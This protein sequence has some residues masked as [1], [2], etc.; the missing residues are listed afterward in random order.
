MSILD[1]A[2]KHYKEQ[3]KEGLLEINV[4][5]WDDKIYYRKAF[6]F[7]TQGKVFQLSNDGLMV[8]AL[9]ETLIQRGLKQDGS[10]AFRPADRIKLMHEVDPNIIIRI[11]AEINGEGS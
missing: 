9:V 6:N 1:K 2:S 7:A 4:P 10:K 5:E 3:L 8:D 11:V